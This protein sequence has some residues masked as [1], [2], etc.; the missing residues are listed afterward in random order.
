MSSLKI[1][2]CCKV[3]CDAGKDESEYSS[4]WTKNEKGKVICPTLLA[5]LCRH[6]NIKG[7]TVSYC[8]ILNKNKKREAFFE[9]NEKVNK[10]NDK[11]NDKQNKKKNKNIINR[12]QALDRDSDE[13]E[14]KDD[15]EEMVEKE[16]VFDRPCTP[17]GPPPILLKPTYAS[18]LCKEKEVPIPVSVPDP[19]PTISKIVLPPKRFLWS[20]YTSDDDLEQED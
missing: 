15:I 7:H 3:C 13:E 12:F 19:T 20:D 8:P 9:K 4:H 1:K 5:L 6:C 10:K 2:P 18:I 17:E 11:Q 14:D 16:E